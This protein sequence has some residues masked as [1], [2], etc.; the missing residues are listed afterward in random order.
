MKP[1]IAPLGIGDLEVIK[2]KLLGFE[3]GEI[4][5]IETVMPFETRSREHRHLKRTEDRISKKPR[6]PRNPFTR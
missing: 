4:A 6:Q 3:P 1:K 2:L 5:H